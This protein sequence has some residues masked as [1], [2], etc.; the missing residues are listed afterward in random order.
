MLA[1]S[2]ALKN[3][4]AFPE[5]LHAC[6]RAY[7]AFVEVGDHLGAARCTTQITGFR[8]MAGDRAGAQAWE[9]RG[10]EHLDKVGPCLERGYHAVACIGCD[11]HDPAT[12]LRL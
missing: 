10:W 2:T 5:A 12:L 9:R 1:W 3:T 7:R 11:I 8:M 6:E 4:G